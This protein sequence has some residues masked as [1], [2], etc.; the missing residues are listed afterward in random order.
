MSD[1]EQ[2]I[3][4]GMPPPHTEGMSRETQTAWIVGAILLVGAIIL[5][6]AT[7]LDPSTRS[8]SFSW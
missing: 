2:E 4:E 8:P 5:Y 7:R 3:H 6:F 1:D